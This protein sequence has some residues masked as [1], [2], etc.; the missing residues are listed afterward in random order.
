MPSKRALFRRADAL[1]ADGSPLLIE[2]LL[3]SN[4]K[5]AS[6][7]ADGLTIDP[8]EADARLQRELEDRP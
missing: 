1:G 8:T 3:L 6:D 2:A 5:R 4:L 7:Y